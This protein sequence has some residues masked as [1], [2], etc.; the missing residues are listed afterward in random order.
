MNGEQFP[1]HFLTVEISSNQF[2]FKY[3]SSNNEIIFVTFDG[4]IFIFDFLNLKVREI[5]SNIK[6]K[7]IFL[8]IHENLIN[9]FTGEEIVILKDEKEFLIL[10]CSNCNFQ[11]FEGNLLGRDGEDIAQISISDLIDG[12]NKNFSKDMNSITRINNEL[13]L[14]DDL[15]EYSTLYAY[16]SLEPLHKFEKLLFP[17]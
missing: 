7:F 4:K 9:C 15:F 3:N 13:F 2:Q 6:Y 5:Y 11:Q 1:S 14:V 17:K 16:P 10:P 8:V 12:K